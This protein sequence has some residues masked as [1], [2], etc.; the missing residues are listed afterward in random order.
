MYIKKVHI[1]NIRSISNFE[2]NFESPA[3]WHVI[4]GDNGSGKSSVLKAIALVLIGNEEISG[5]RLNWDNFIRVEENQSRATVNFISPAT[6]GESLETTIPNYLKFT[7]SN[8]KLPSQAEIKSGPS[9]ADYR[10]W[11]EFFSTSFGPFRRFKGGSPEWDS[12]YK[13]LPNLAAHLSLF[14]ESVALSEAIEWLKLLKF[15][16]LEN[17]SDF[18]VLSYFIKTI[19]SKG[20]L[21]FGYELNEVSSKGVYLK[22][23]DGFIIDANELSDGYRSVLS[24]TFELFRQLFRVYGDEKV[25]ARTFVGINGLVSIDLP[26]VVLID[27]IDAH[28]HPTW[29]TRIGQWFTRYFPNLQFIITTHSPLIC[30]AAEKGTIWRLAAP[31]SNEQSGEVTGTDR[32]RLI[33]GNVLDAY[34]TE[35][36]GEGVSI[37]KES[38]DKLTELAALNVKSLFEEVTDK[39]KQK[40]QELKSVFPSSSTMLKNG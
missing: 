33:Y 36:F 13:S 6:L 9:R 8:G 11:D 19:N 12:V 4:I 10:H 22:N 31:G 20:F 40:M 21:P 24:L 26:G 7:R 17:P 27:E 18:D 39:E 30:R 15:E 38:D 1:E 37:S 35:V 3:G 29:Q 25:F 5:L 16:Q 14:D 23:S 28:L 2:M 34:G 32:D